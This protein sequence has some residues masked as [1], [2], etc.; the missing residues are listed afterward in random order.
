MENAAFQTWSLEIQT[1]QQR[2]PL[3]S[4]RRL[5]WLFRLASWWRLCH[6]RHCQ[7]YRALQACVLFSWS[8]QAA[9]YSGNTIP[10]YQ[11]TPS[12]V[13]SGKPLRGAPRK[14]PSVAPGFPWE[15]FPIFCLTNE[16]Y[17]LWNFLKAQTHL[18]GGGDSRVHGGE[19]QMYPEDGVCLHWSRS[20]I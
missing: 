14:N 4:C 12:N 2:A 5:H 7:K 10:E 19:R 15:Y 3:K 11:A 6:H 17:R 8:K 1:R 18:F 9:V 20:C 16:M 13:F